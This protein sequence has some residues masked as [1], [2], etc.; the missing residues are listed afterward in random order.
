MKRQ[1]SPPDGRR[2]FRHSHHYQESQKEQKATVHRFAKQF[3]ILAVTASLALAAAACKNGA[4][5]AGAKDAAVAATV[6]GQNIMLSEVDRIISQQT[7]GQQSKMSPLQLGAAR[8]QVLDS[9]IQ[10]HVLVLRAEKEKIVPTDDDINAAINAQKTK[11]TAEEWDKF[12]KEN[13]MTEQQ[14]REEARKD[15][16]IRKLQEKLFGQ[17]SI[18]EQEI[19]D[20]F[21]NNKAQF[22]D[23]RGVF[24]SDIVVDPRDSAGAFQDDA[25]SEAEAAAKINR[26]HAQLLGGADF[27]TV[28]RASSEDQSSIRGGDIGFAGE[29]DLKQNG[30]PPELVNSFF[31]EMQVGSFTKPIRFGD[32]RWYI[33]KLTNRQLETKPQT[34]DDPAVKEQIKNGLIEQRRT[35]LGEALIRNAM[36]DAQV[37]NN[38]AGKMLE[39]PSSLGGLVPASPAGGAPAPAATASPAATPSPAATAGASATPAA[40][41]SPSPAAK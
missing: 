5:G 2:I 7:G 21:N 19:V 13:N 23:P 11:G 29:Q 24:I 4:T 38:L 1:V 20:F 25:K 10:R 32:G 30:F 22:V 8:L 12:L 28:A 40:I 6:N 3:A 14:L 34:L 36:S 41:A 37:V 27:A 39:D 18:R 26:L 33:F 15:I 31:N 9:L 16:A 17:I 35:L